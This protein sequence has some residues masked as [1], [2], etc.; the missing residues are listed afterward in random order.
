MKKV[1]P[2]LETITPTFGS[3]F[4]VRRFEDPCSNS[5][6]FWHFHPE[7][8]LVYVKGGSGKRH[9]GNHLSYFHDGDLIF[10]GSNLPHSGFTD[11]LT[12]NESEI[13][14]QMKSDFL[15]TNFF[16]IPE[17]A[18]IKQLFERAK[19]G[20]AFHGVTKEIVG[21]RL[22]KL[23]DL[24]N[25]ERLVE[26]LSILRIMEASTE[27]Q[28]LN[29]EEYALEVRPQDNDRIRKVYQFVRKNFDRQISL[30]E[31]ASIANMTVPA[32]CRYFKKQSGKTFTQFVNEVRIVHACK[33]LSEKASSIT[34]I[35]F[36]S[37]FNSF[38][39]FNKSFKEITGKSPSDYRKELKQIVF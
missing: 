33:L 12:G 26:L 25:F 34:E 24:E 17:M 3:S 32:F 10:I 30:E 28:V 6:P 22:S 14:V 37:G 21:E 4:T 23:P 1:K 36:E 9:I 39:H 16:D 38:S 11:R 8:E 18:S 20:I 19:M 29:A 27:Y 15:G 2:A 31:I 35:S 13:V 5:N 7:L